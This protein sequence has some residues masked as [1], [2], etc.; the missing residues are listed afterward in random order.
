MSKK[1]STK[2][3]YAKRGNISLHLKVKNAAIC[4]KELSKVLV[5]LMEKELGE[6]IL[7]TMVTKCK[8]VSGKHRLL[9]IVNGDEK[10][11]KLLS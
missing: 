9:F 6:S 2:L 5:P 8:S 4:L 7:R 10:K 1:Q 3:L 11:A